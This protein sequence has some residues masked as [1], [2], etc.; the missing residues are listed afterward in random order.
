VIDNPNDY[1][2]RGV[3]VNFTYKL[4]SIVSA[5]GLSLL[6]SLTTN[7]STANEQIIER[8]KTVSHVCMEG[9]DT[10]GSAIAAVSTGGPARTGEEVYTTKCG[11]CH[12]AG[13]SG[14]PKFGSAD[15]TERGAKGIESLLA[16]AIS[17]VGAMPAKGLC[18]DCS[19]DELK[20]AIEH[21]LNS[22][23]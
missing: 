20:G 16:T 14:A 7:A 1:D 11:L 9:D 19:D 10:C 22:A 3:T 2:K 5:L 8:I 17:G 15:W 21:M 13:V 4:A 12:A 6:V 18:T 23:P